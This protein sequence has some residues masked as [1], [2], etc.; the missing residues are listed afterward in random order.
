MW[1]DAFTL[2]SEK[3]KVAKHL[4]YFRNKFFCQNLSKYP[5]LVTFTTIG[6]WYPHSSWHIETNQ[7][8]DLRLYLVEWKIGSAFCLPKLCLLRPIA[9]GCTFSRILLGLCTDHME[10]QGIKYTTTNWFIFTVFFWKIEFAKRERKSLGPERSGTN[11][12]FQR[13]RDPILDRTVLKLLCLGIATTCYVWGCES[14]RRIKWLTLDL[15][16]IPFGEEK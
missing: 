16:S 1:S 11:N 9:I 5:N 8:G 6:N 3:E 12:L 14:W 4:G 7:K 2:K 10:E 13:E 15:G